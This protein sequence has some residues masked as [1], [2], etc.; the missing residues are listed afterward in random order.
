MVLYDFI[1]KDANRI[2]SFYA[3]LFNG[4]LT[5][6]QEKYDY[7]EDK[8]IEKQLGTKGTFKNESLTQKYIQEKIIETDP[9]DII[10]IDT[11]T[12]LSSNSKS[13][14]E[15]RNNEIIKINGNIFFMNK[16]ILEMFLPNFSM[17]FDS[18]IKEN[19]L[20]KSQKKVL[21]KQFKN[22]LELLK[23]L[24]F[25]PLVFVFFQNQIAIGVIKEKYLDEP[26]L[27]YLARYG[28]QGIKDIT[29][30][31]IKEEKAIIDLTNNT[32]GLYKGTLDFAQ[33]INQM[34]IPPNAYIFTP[35][36]ILRN[37]QLDNKN[38]E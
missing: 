4:L 34:I 19:N 35:I 11:L 20:D 23:N 1:Y 30:L 32:D 5:K 17:F 9:H 2:Y 21:E 6:N 24:K 13:I 16:E 18:L 33:A 10:T 38:V 25:E 31:G 8:K 29:I 27:S 22:I 15:A 3:Q 36:A 37:I 28:N 14:T 26:I 12:I 7:G